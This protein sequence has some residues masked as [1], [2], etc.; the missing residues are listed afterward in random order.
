MKKVDVGGERI[1]GIV[2]I[3]Y[4]VFYSRIGRPH[5]VLGVGWA[6]S[7]EQV[8]DTETPERKA[9]SRENNENSPTNT[10]NN[11]RTGNLNVRQKCS[12]MTHWTKKDKQKRKTLH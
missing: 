7:K 9:L 3:M 5:I 10:V 6:D 11:T 4:T 1:D 2:W 8:G 12:I